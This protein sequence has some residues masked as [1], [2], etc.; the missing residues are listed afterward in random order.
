LVGGT[1]NYYSYSGGNS[2][3]ITT[4]TSDYVTSSL[5]VS[6]SGA[7]V[8]WKAA[9][10]TNDPTYSDSAQTTNALVQ[11]IITGPTIS[12]INRNASTNAITNASSY[13][14]DVT[15]SQA[16]T[17]VTSGK[18]SLS[19]TR[20]G[21]GIS[22]VTSSDNITWMVT[23]S[24][25]T[26]DGTLGVNLSD[27]SGITAVS[28]G[29]ALTSTRNADQ[30]TTIDTTAP[31]ISNVTLNAATYKLGSTVTATMQLSGSYDGNGAYTLGTGSTLD[32]MTLTGWSYDSAN[33]RGTATFTVTGS[34][35]EV[36][37]G[38][39]ATGI[40]V[41]DALGN[42]S[43]TYSSGVPSITIDA[44]VPTDIA[45]NN[46]S[47][48][49]TGGANAVVGNLSTTDVTTGETFT[50]TL[51]AGAGAT[52]NASFNISGGNLRANDPNALGAGTYSVRVRSTDA[53]GN[54]FEKV[55][56]SSTSE[57]ELARFRRERFAYL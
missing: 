43:T 16:V 36:I 3:V 50:Y 9:S 27:I 21:G 17:G 10:P 46:N 48:S 47:I 29:A 25:V 15:F 7:L 22:S 49:T 13:S 51:V 23:V 41:K 24:G 11:R 28:G 45:L 39:V 57:V 37:N 12:S 4:S 55:F 42:A 44:Q 56:A 5:A 35:T 31:T 53:G 54:T 30:T 26:G 8:S 40:V 1:L 52:D 6:P 20:T 38:S 32:G 18:F 19:G 14:F 2:S 34:T 33:N